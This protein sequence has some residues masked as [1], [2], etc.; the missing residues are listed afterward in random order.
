MTD[1][2]VENIIVSFPIASSLDLS[3]LAEILP[4]TKYNPDEVPALV[5]QFIK[6][7]SMVTLFSTGKVVVTGPKS[8][9]DVQAVVKMV[10]DRLTV[11]GVPVE[12]TPEI[13][14]Q[15]VTGSTDL[16]RPLELRNLSK[17]L[18]PVDYNPKVFP[19]LVYKADDP[20]TVILLFDSGKIICNSPTQEA[21]T[22]ALDKIIEKLLSFGI[23]KEE[24]VCWK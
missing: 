4:D 5:I 3:K 21:V 14:V 1:V 23:K 19:G 10:A 2:Q 24:N 22:V 12:T 16:H 6:P 18:Q 9:E 8:M 11:V 20:N 13:T 15:N 7:R 17:L